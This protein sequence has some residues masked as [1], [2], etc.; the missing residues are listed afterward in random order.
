[1]D[2]S[3]DPSRSEQLLAPKAG[4]TNIF[5]AAKPN[6]FSGAI[7]TT[8]CHSIFFT[9]ESVALAVPTALGLLT[10][11]LLL[12]CVCSNIFSS[13]FFVCIFPELHPAG[14]AL[15]AVPAVFKCLSPCSSA[16]PKEHA[17]CTF[18]LALILYTVHM[19]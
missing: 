6:A 2:V 12:T 5:C 11:G 17:F 4:V 3:T 19:W 8:M 1:M 13:M 7:S 15:L 9:E 16:F 14:P 18:P 10:S